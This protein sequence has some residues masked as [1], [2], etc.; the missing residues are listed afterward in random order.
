MART[1]HPQV[2]AAGSGTGWARF[3]GRCI[4]LGLTLVLAVYSLTAAA[5]ID[6]KYP[7]VRGYFPTAT[8]FGD[9]EGKPAAAAVYQGKK[10]IGYV[11]E[12]VMVAPVPA[13]SGKPINILIA[14]NTAGRILHTKVLYQDEPILL[15][16]IP[17]QRLYDFVHRYIGRNVTDHVVV[18]GS[19]TPGSIKIDAI[20]S[21][22]VTSMV[23]N[24]TIM[25]AALEVAVSRHLVSASLA[26]ASHATATVRQDYFKPADWQQLTGNG[27]I[28][29]LTLTRGM[30]AAGFKG[31]PVNDML[32]DLTEPRPGEAGQPFIDLYYTDVTPPTVGRNLLGGNAYTALAR[33]LKPGDEAIALLANGPFSFKGVGYVRGGVFDRI[34]V[35]QDGKLFLF[36]DSDF[37]E[38]SQPELAGAPQFEQRGIFILRH[39]QG[40]NP[41]APWT[42]QLAVNRQIG[43][44]KRI[45]NTFSAS[46]QIPAAYVVQPKVA[47]VS[48][49]A[50]MWKQIWYGQR[51]QIAALVAGLAVLMVILTFQDWFVKRKRLFER[52]RVGFLIYTLVFIGWYGLAQLSVV[53]ILTFVHSVLHGFQWSTFLMDPLVF[54]LWVFVA[55]MLLLFGRGIYCGWLCPFGALQELVN[56]A[57]KRLKVPQFEFPQFVHERLW[58]IKYVILLGLFGVS[59]QSLG[60]A[61]RYAEVEPFKTA[62]VLHFARSWAFVAYAGAL[63]LVSAFNHRFY[64]RYV[65]PLGAGLAVSGKFHLFEWLRRRKECGHPCQICTVEC[66][67]RAIDTLGAINYNECVYCLECQVNYEDDEKCPPLVTLRKIRE[68]AARKL[69]PG[70]TLVKDAQGKP[71]FEK[72]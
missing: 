72:V 31:Q 19:S 52:I 47:P 16:G 71:V 9:I 5:G 54:L 15:V 42:L 27:A 40:F 29:R 1:L 24:E 30:V 46:Y 41:G 18:G 69:P 21:A 55:V 13:Y 17:V 50:P 32:G 26:D 11:F 7:E 63:V 3:A 2:R 58:A 66:P 23:T 61:E 60:L 56:R 43:P 12:S 59:L 34:H 6:Q 14:I 8:R 49:N 62:I 36:K 51:Y 22:T 35:M 64:C 37:V 45:Y 48:S 10:V 70:V 44:L 57:A 39:G 4:L 20:S 38:M 68:K 67:V 33:D 25:N 53:N 65:C 28:R